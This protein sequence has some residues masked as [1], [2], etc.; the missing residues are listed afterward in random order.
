MALLGVAFYCGTAVLLCLSSGETL[1]LPCR[2]CRPGLGPA[3]D[4]LFCFAK[5]VGKKGDPMIAPSLREGP[6]AVYA[7]YCPAHSLLWP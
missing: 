4:L 7:Q 3:A 1:R 5:K 2:G 6:R